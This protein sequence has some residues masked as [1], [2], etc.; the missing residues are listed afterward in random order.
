MGQDIF[1][2]RAEKQKVSIIIRLFHG[3]GHDFKF[4]DEVLMKV[5]LVIFICIGILLSACSIETIEE[6]S[7]GST[8]ISEAVSDTI[9]EVSDEESRKEWVETETNGDTKITREYRDGKNDYTVTT[10]EF[11]E[12]GAIISKKITVYKKERKISSE[13][14]YYHEDGTVSKSNK[15]IFTETGEVDQIESYDEYEEYSIV[16]NLKMDQD[17]IAYEGT[18]EYLSLDGELLAKG[19]RNRESFNGYDCSVEKLEVYGSDKKIDHF[20]TFV[21]YITGSPYVYKEIF[22]SEGNKLYSREVTQEAETA[23]IFGEDGC[24]IVTVND[25]SVYTD[26]DGDLIAELEG[27][28][29][30]KIGENYSVDSIVGVIEGYI[31]LCKQYED[32]FFERF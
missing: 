3:H 20:E 19:T 30:T 8:G 4:I 13:N 2:C 7:S 15:T 1:G 9:S 22:D 29:I 6:S 32:E 16:S 5:I 26:R 14:Y 24:M 18:V 25:T 11:D 23:Y 12:N 21:T 17:G 10:E 31:A 28:T 27:L